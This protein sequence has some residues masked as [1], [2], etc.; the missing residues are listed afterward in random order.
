MSQ[1]LRKRGRE[2]EALPASTGV[3][4]AKRFHDEET[5]RF[6]RLLQADKAIAQEEEKCAPSEEVVNGVMRSLEE[7]IDFT[8][9]LSSNSG[10]NSAPSNIS[11]GQEGETLPAD[12]VVD[13]FNLLE[14]PDNEL[15]IPLSPVLDEVWQSPKETSESLLENP[16]LKSLGEIW[17]F[18]DEFENHQQ[19]A[20]YEDACEA[21]Q[22]HDY[23]N[24]DFLSEDMFFDCDFSAPWNFEAAG[25]L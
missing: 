9:F 1:T 3:T 6:C 24:R 5:E 12:L 21:S 15:S 13:L 20:P 2:P 7:E 4:E 11:S 10:A 22:V 18:E 8:S 16:D 14:A 17:H 25:C 19:F 23:L